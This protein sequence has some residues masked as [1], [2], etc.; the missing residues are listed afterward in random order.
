MSTLAPPNLDIASQIESVNHALTAG[1]LA[2]LLSVS[3]ITIYKLA[4]TKKIP[5][6]RL[7]SSVR[8]CGRSVASWLRRQAVN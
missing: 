6:I 4:R 1:E 8:F 2:A 7:G 5:H 3:K